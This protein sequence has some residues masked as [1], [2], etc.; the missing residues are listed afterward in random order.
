MIGIRDLLPRS[1]RATQTDPIQTVQNTDPELISH[2]VRRLGMG[3]NVDLVTAVSTVQ[4]AIDRCLVPSVIAP[5][6][7][8]TIPRSW[9]TAYEEEY[10]PV[11]AITSWWI[12]QMAAANSPI[13]ERMS[14]FWHDHFSMTADKADVGWMVWRHLEG[15][16]EHATGNFRDM[17]RHVAH[18]SAMLVYLD[19]EANSVWDL[20]ENFGREVLELYTLGVGNYSQ[21]DVI[22]AA[23]C[24]TGNRP[25]FP[26]EDTGEGFEDE[27]VE[28]WFPKF[29]EDDFDQEPRT[30]L[31]QTGVFTMDEALDIML[32]HPQTGRFIA[33]KLY[34]ELVGLEPDDETID[35]L[36]ALFGSDYEIMPLVEAI[37][38]DPAF[39][40]P[41]AVRSKVRTPLEKLITIQQSYPPEED[42]DIWDYNWATGK[43]GYGPFRAPNPAGYKKGTVLLSPGTLASSFVFLGLVAEYPPDLSAEEQFARLGLFD[44]SEHSLEVVSSAADGQGLALAY[45]SPEFLL[46]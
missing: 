29:F 34:R 18:S 40:S 6:P 19:G 17:L 27:S 1:K 42:W 10:A 44:V 22:A 46:T 33:A 23:R 12:Q 31:G 20:N 4:E 38:A 21:D 9:D 39:T 14:W 37:V 36:G 35:R 45:G 28:G 11:P 8:I 5:P 16:R 13:Q 26:M 32:E 30:L 41:E 2:V 25:N 43:A 3:A 24:C 7:D 15:L